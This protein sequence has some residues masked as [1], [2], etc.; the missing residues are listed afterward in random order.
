MYGG[1]ERQRHTE[2]IGLG[3][4]DLGGIWGKRKT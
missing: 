4:S 2:R 1:R 3:R